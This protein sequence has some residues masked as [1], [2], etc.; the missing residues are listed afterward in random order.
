MPKLILTSYP[1]ERVGDFVQVSICEG[2]KPFPSETVEISSAAD[3]A[4]ALDAYAAKV[5]ATGQGAQVSMRLEKRRGD[6]APTGFNK[7]RGHLDVNC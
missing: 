7:L 1:A 2:G 6:R 4:A 5:K 3:A